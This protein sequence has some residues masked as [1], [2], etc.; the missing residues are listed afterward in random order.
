MEESD[1]EGLATHGGP[2]PCGGAREGVAEALDRGTC[3]RAIE[4]RN[5]VSG[6][7]TLSKRRKATPSAAQARVAGGPRGVEEP[8]HARNLHA[9]EPG[10]VTNVEGNLM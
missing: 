9:R 5:R 1:I 8:L 7:P 10:C 4:P 3:R 6:V 2:E